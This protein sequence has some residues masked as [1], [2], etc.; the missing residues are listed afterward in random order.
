MMHNIKWVVIFF[1]LCII[2]LFIVTETH[3]FKPVTLKQTSPKQEL[4][5]D[6]KQTIKLFQE[7]S[8]SVVFI[9]TKV[10]VRDF[11]SRN[12]Y[13]VP[14]G[15]GS[16]FVWDNKGYIVTNYHVIKDASEANVRFNDGKNY[17][18]SLVGASIEHDLAVLKIFSPL[19]KKE[20]LKIGT[21]FDLKVGQKV[22]AI[23]NPFGLDYTLTSGIVS[24]LGRTLEMDNN[25]II[26]NLI[27]TD[28][29]INPG[30]SGGP[31]LDSSGRL[32]GVNTAIYS[33]SG[34]SAGVGFAVPVDIVNKVVSAII[35][36]GEYRRPTIGI[37]INEELNQMIQKEQGIKGVVILDVKNG[38]SAQL[39]GLKGSKI[40]MY[41]NIILGDIITHINGKKVSSI[42]KLLNILDSYHIG[43][44]VSVD[45]IR[46]TK[47]NRV[48]ITLK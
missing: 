34:A 4:Y 38:S 39:V 18:A 44:K 20:P 27:Q 25:F 14:K 11:W 5:F 42:T 28:A 43:D 23:G 9:T 3:D 10:N 26:E 32:I 30:N 6:E 46:D 40:D 29:A 17:K 2:G 31:L 15:T 47:T 33:P 48:E 35:A 12:I 41:N 22:F 13:T 1:F 24:A 19:D 21:S 36:K 7:A 37:V 16:G 8:P 45:Y